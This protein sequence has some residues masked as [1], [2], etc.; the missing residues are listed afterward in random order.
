MKPLPLPTGFG[1][2]FDPGVRLLDDATLSGGA[3]PRILRLAPAGRRALQEL[4]CGS[5]TTAAGGAL[6]RKLTDAGLLHPRPPALREPPDATVVIPVRDRAPQLDRCLAGLGRAYPVI[7]VDDGSRD[8]SAVAACAARHGAAIVHRAR[9]G[10]PGAARNTGLRHVGT[11][12]VVMVDSDCVPAPGWIERLAAHL[13]DPLVAVAAPR[14]VPLPTAEPATA[15]SRYNR[16]R[17]S[18]DLG[19]REAR[20][21]PL[22]RVAYV[23]TAA[24]VVR[25]AALLDVARGGDVF[26]PAMTV[27][28]D[29]DLIWRLHHAGWRIRYDPAVQVWHD[30]PATWPALLSRRFRYG[31]SAPLLARRHPAE[32]PPLVLSPLPAATVAAMLARWPLAAG[33]G[34]TAAVASAARTL[35]RAGVPGDPVRGAVPAMLGA[36]YRTWLS[37]GRYG[38]QFASPL[39][40]AAVLT[41]AVGRERRPWTR[42][43]AAASLLLGPGLASWYE[44]RRRLDPARFTAA[45]IADDIAYG[46][47]VWFGSVRHRTLSAIRPVIAGGRPS[48]RSST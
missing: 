45:S 12:I 28:E 19:D 22:T 1:V 11:E 35:H 6:A 7:V 42:R 31:S 30:E 23:P 38:V 3:P 34:F 13:A 9:N 26:D 24:L 33:A 29:V 14:I 48:D 17:G 32:M 40:V 18:L 10:G 47:G 43:L 46:S 25:R 4:R 5:V 21:V 36:T 15:V 20:V 27:G 8:P 2:V 44:H 41:P 16:A 37:L 39:L